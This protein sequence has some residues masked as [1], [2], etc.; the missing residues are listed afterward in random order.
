MKAI[1]WSKVRGKNGF[2]NENGNGTRKLWKFISKIKF[3]VGSSLLANKRF[4][5]AS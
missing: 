2:K 4:M 5:Q 1:N 3:Y